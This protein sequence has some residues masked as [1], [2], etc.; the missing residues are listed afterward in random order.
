MDI[1]SDD[2]IMK[3]VQNGHLGL[4]GLLFERYKKMLYGFFYNQTSNVVMSE[5]LVQ[6]TFYRVIKYK[7]H[8]RGDQQFK[9]WIFTIAR[10]AMKDE[11][12]KNK[13]K[14]Q[15][16]DL[17]KNHFVDSTASDENLHQED[18]QNILQKALNQLSP[19]KKEILILIKL[20][21]KKYKEVADILGMNESTVK[22]KVFRAI[23]DL[24]TI[25]KKEAHQF[26]L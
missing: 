3:K 10:N 2:A 9:A 13:N 7:H 14:H 21:G 22:S 16:I 20:N 4:S 18:K 1:L 11:F 23:K 25:Y 24:Q 19:E 6:N 8:Y 15:D 26:K 5:D 12:R 17:Y